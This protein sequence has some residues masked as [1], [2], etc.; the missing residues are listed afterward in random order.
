MYLPSQAST[1]LNAQNITLREY[2]VCPTHFL[3]FYF[4]PNISTKKLGS[5]RPNALLKFTSREVSNECLKALF[6]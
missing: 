5:E 2:K 1:S 6:P 4:H 3:S